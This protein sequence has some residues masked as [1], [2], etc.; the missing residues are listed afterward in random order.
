MI[1]T[2]INKYLIFSGYYSSDDI[3]DLFQE[4]S[5]DLIK[6]KEKII[7]SYKG[8]AKFSTYL[9]T[10]VYYKCI[11][12][13]RNKIAQK[14]REPGFINFDSEK[15]SY[16]FGNIRSDELSSE[17]RV[18]ILEFCARL[19]DILE[20]YNKKKHKITFCL[21]SLFRLLV[22]L[23]DLQF[24]KPDKAATAKIND[25]A[26][27][28]NSTESDLTDQEVYALLT[29]I[30]N[31]LERKENSNDAIRK[32]IDDRQDEIVSLLNGTG[33]KVC[34][35]RETFQILFEYCFKPSI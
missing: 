15:L 2:I 16:W 22:L 24:Y 21:K 4:M 35:N 30:F 31:L 32:W 7:G 34:F 28:L 17:T 13:M 10:I 3:E 5:L 1:R 14:T 11:E 29:I 12:M 19:S 20:T 27:R 25:C 9:Y 18:I 26:A 8:S 33:S 23:A 6:R